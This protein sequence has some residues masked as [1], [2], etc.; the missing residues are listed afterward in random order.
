MTKLKDEWNVCKAEILQRIDIKATAE[1][2]GIRFT[3]DTPTPEVGYRATPSAAQTRSLR[4][5]Y[6]LRE[7]MASWAVTQTSAATNKPRRFR[8]SISVCSLEHTPIGWRHSKL[9]RPRRE[10]KLPA[11]QGKNST[12]NSPSL[13]DQ[14]SFINDRGT[15]Q[16]F[17]AEWVQN[18]VGVTE[19][20]AYAAR[21]KAG[22]WPK[23]CANGCN[24]EGG[25]IRWLQSDRLENAHLHCSLIGLMVRISRR[26]QTAIHLSGKPISFAALATA[27]SW[28]AIQKHSKPP[29]IGKSGNSRCAGSR[30]S[31]PAQPR[32]L[33]EHA[34]GQVDPEKVSRPRFKE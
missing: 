4:P 24:H 22:W 5:Q 14:I 20:S 33:H 11:R 26:A 32:C 9:L 7:K 16:A 29:R 3:S 13:M 1:R 31:T 8:T 19:E 34:R 15:E 28:S 27:S 30:R 6:V 25:C 18:K 17:V 10:A 2:R 23:K 12:K 21:V